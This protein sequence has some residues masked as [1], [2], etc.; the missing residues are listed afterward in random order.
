MKYSLYK[1]I[2]CF[3]PNQFLG[4][5]IT[6]NVNSSNSNI[7]GA[8]AEI[9]GVDDRG[10]LQYLETFH[11]PGSAACKLFG[12]ASTQKDFIREAHNWTYIN[13]QQRLMVIKETCDPILEEV[14][15]RAELIFYFLPDHFELFL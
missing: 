3:Y 12:L 7:H 5:H 9:V 15:S 13:K 11:W 8:Y 1:T 10:E 4:I 2:D 6:S 14:S